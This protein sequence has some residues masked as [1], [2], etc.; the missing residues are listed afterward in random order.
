MNDERTTVIVRDF[1]I[2]NVLELKLAKIAE[3]RVVDQLVDI[4]HVVDIR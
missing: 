1:I 3:H 2:R 4:D